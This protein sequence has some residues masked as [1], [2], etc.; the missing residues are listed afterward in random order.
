M[1]ANKKRQLLTLYGS[2]G[3]LALVAGYRLMGRDGTAAVAETSIVPQ[4]AVKPNVAVADIL[5]LDETPT[6]A[7]PTP[8]DLHAMLSDGWQRPK[9]DPFVMSP[10]I[11]IAAGRGPKAAPAAGET[12][13]ETK[14]PPV[15]TPPSFAVRSTC[16]ISGKWFAEIDGRLYGVGDVVRGFRITRIKNNALWA[17]PVASATDGGAVAVTSD[18]GRPSCVMRVGETRMA[19]T[20][21]RW[22]ST[23]ET[24]GRGMVRSVNERGISYENTVDQS[25]TQ[26]AGNDDEYEVRVDPATRSGG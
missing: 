16:S 8:E 10:R 2:I 18:G 11:L 23:G 13:T 20:N 26:G 22:L 4:V 3:V 9:H 6:W 24:T 1:A 25:G 17:L 12:V 7:L 15:R 19:L 14:P 21:G 5:S